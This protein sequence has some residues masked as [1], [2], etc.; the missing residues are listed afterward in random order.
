[1]RTCQRRFAFQHL[2]A[3]GVANDGFRR[4]AY[5]AKQSQELAVWQGHVVH[6]VLANEFLTE[7]R[8]RRYPKLIDLTA[9]ADRILEDQLSFSR[10]GHYHESGMSKAAAGRSYCVLSVHLR[11][12]DVDA[13]ALEDIRRSISSCFEFILDQREFVQ[14]MLSSQD[15]QAELK[16]RFPVAGW[17]VRAT[18]DLVFRAPTGQLWVVD[19]KVAKSLTS[20]YSHQLRLYALALIR[21]GRGA[22]KDFASIRLIEANL[23][24]MQLRPHPLSEETLA[25]AEDYAFRGV[26]QLQELL[27]S[28][29]DQNALLDELDTANAPAT[30]GY[31]PFSELCIEALVRAGR[32]RD[33]EVVQGTLW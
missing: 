3:S 32:A 12:G 23:L 11:G 1:M 30:C 24:Q 28:E 20:D 5:I 13:A 26:I 25:Q 8:R 29:S 2:V 14:L 33:A 6:D 7:I 22:V 4:R 15:H 18:L 9:A 16:L 31:C 21:S 17:P 27:S 10:G 19:W